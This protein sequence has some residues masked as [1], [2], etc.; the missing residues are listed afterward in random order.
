MKYSFFMILLLAFNCCA[1]GQTQ[2]QMNE[3]AQKKFLLTEKDLNNVYN[4]ILLSYKAD[5]A[6][7]K[8]IKISQRLWLKLRD[9][10]MLAKYPEREQG[11]YGSVSPMC[12][13]IYKEELT[14]G[15]VE[16]LK[17]WITGIEE[18]DVCSGSVRI[19]N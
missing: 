2:L 16:K 15:R 4:K 18:G 9:A 5:T 17:I 12:W 10:E 19:K 6:F 11:Y 7:I 3:D 13:S 14:R 8:N 1:F